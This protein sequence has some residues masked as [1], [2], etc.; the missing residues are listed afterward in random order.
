MNFDIAKIFRIG[1]L[2]TNL[3]N[4]RKKFKKRFLCILNTIKCNY[5]VIN[6]LLMG[7]N[8]GD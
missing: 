2:I 4:T 6:L 3:E 1:E 5:F 7:E 8:N